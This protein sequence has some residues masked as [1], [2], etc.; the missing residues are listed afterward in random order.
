MLWTGKDCMYC[1]CYSSSSSDHN[2]TPMFFTSSINHFIKTSIG[3]WSLENHKAEIVTWFHRAGTGSSLTKD[4]TGHIENLLD[5]NSG[6]P[7]LLNV[8][9]RSLQAKFSWF[10]MLLCKSP[11]VMSLYTVR[12]W[13]LACRR[14][15][16]SWSV[17]LACV[18]WAS[19]CFFKSNMI[20]KPRSRHQVLESRL[21]LFHKTY[22]LWAL[23]AQVICPV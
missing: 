9:V 19:I 6:S 16:L 23:V 5:S 4:W 14:R 7:S 8:S 18:N 21:C 3:G 22:M 2:R 15:R 20:K 10:C 17:P 12:K 1:R 13:H 11:S